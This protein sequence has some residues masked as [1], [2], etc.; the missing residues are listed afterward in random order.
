MA[1]A[2]I[3]LQTIPLLSSLARQRVF[4]DRLNLNHDVDHLTRHR[5]TKV[6]LFSIEERLSTLFPCYNYIIFM[7]QTIAYYIIQLLN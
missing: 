6:I 3:L 2:H 4:R 7:T 5:A 1:L